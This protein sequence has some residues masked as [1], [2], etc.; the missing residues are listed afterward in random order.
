VFTT[1]LRLNV[2]AVLALAMLLQLGTAVCAEPLPP[3][4]PVGGKPAKPKRGEVLKL[5]GNMI[6]AMPYLPPMDNQRSEPKTYVINDATRISIGRLTGERTTPAGGQE[7]SFKAEPGT[8][9]DLR[10]GQQVRIDAD[11]DR[12]LRILIFPESASP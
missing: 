2:W 12:A 8:R 10:V 7:K 11:G 6:T 9:D 3:N 4:A 5:E 1:K